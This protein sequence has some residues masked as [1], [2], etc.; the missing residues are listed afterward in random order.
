MNLRLPVSILATTAL[1]GS[2]AVTATAVSSDSSP[3]GSLAATAKVNKGKDPCTKQPKLKG[4]KPGQL[5]KYQELAVDP[6]LMT[7]AR[8]FRVLYTTSGVDE[9]NT[10][11]TCG[12]VLIPTQG[13]TNEIVAWAHGTVGVHQACQPSNNPDGFLAGGAVKYGDVVK[14]SPKD[15]VLQGLIN[16]GRMITATDY[17]SG[18]GQPKKYQQHYVLGVP[19]AAAV[20]DS[21]RIGIQLS[22]KIGA[23]NAPKWKMAIWGASQGGHA[24]MFAGQLARDY[25]KKMATK[26]EPK[27]LPM[28]VV[29]TVPASSFVATKK[30]PK[31]LLGRH[32][33]DLEM[34]EAMAEVNGQQVGA[35]GPILFSLVMTSWHQY[36]SSGKAAKKPAFPGYPK[37]VKVDEKAVL[38]GPK[39]GNGLGAAQIVSMSCIGEKDLFSLAAATQ[40]FLT[41]PKTNQFFVQPIWGKPDK[42]GV[43]HGRLDKTCMKKKLKK[44]LRA[45]CDWMAYNMPGPAGINPFQKFPRKADG[46]YA[47]V[48]IG[49]GMDDTLI[50][51]QNSGTSVPKARDCMSRQLYD[52]LS[53]KKVCKAT[54]VQL[55]LFAKTPSSPASHLSTTM[56]LADNGNAAYDGSPMDTFLNQ[57]FDESIQPGCGARVVNK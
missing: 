11:A 55:D 25:F 40:R 17:T 35:A 52:A 53:T 47:P 9:K 5:L 16:E 3:T 56:Q 32:L 14:G 12:L 38:T 2:L 27:I 30:S 7:G 51:C 57:A 24:A 15:G 21:A 46:S 26:K 44:G 42:K 54:S 33:A 19:A 41:D 6:T 36:P 28:G 23:L 49:Q 10:Q 4:K 18:M 48:L 37:G 29:A 39:D 31:S 34:H 8:M 20:L 43:W 13:Q 50:Y 45:W 22:K 1:I